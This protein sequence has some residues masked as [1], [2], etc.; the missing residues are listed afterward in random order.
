MTLTSDSPFKCYPISFFIFYHDIYI[1][2]LLNP[3]KY[4]I[5]FEN[6]R[7]KKSFHKIKHDNLNIFHK[8][9]L[10]KNKTPK[11]EQNLLKNKAFK[12]TK[13]KKKFKIRKNMEAPGMII[14]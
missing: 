11:K 2:S 4:N 9:T 6:N 5:V 7:N 12:D 3:P 13:N 1:F 10:K 14:S 8:N